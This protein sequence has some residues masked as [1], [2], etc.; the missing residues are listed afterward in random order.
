M[1]KSKGLLEES[2]DFICVNEASAL[3]IILAFYKGA[4][5]E[6]NLNPFP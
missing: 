5:I 3:R 2:Y 4:S 1:W 6:E